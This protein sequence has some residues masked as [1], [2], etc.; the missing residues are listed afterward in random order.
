MLSL[1]EVA[2]AQ[3][4]VRKIDDDVKERL[5]QR[6]ARHGRS[7]EE[8]VRVILSEAVAED[9]PSTEGLGTRIARNFAWLDE[10]FEVPEFKGWP[11]RPATFDE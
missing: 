4:V 6:A 5:R 8:E 11:A 3:L 10:P 7:M 2:M 1:K 9:A